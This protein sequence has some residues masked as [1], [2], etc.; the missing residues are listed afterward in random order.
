M[1]V[2]IITGCQLTLGDLKS[3]VSPFDLQNEE[4]LMNY[5]QSSGV[6]VIN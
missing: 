3:G 1:T 5:I 4:L 2:L 6:I